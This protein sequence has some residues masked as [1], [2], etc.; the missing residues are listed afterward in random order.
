MRLRNAHAQH[1]GWYKKA[2]NHEKM[3]GKMHGVAYNIS[4]NFVQNHSEVNRTIKQGK[5]TCI[6]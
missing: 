6:V 3:H 1:F 2:P 5:G 4:V